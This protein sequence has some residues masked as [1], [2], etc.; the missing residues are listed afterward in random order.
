[1][2]KLSDQIRFS[3]CSQWMKSLSSV[4]LLWSEHFYFQQVLVYLDKYSNSISGACGCRCLSKRELLYI[5]THM[6]NIQMRQA[7]KYK[8]KGVFNKFL[9]FIA[10]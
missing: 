7:H 8:N 10:T 3:P 2:C 9:K 1:M 4:Q 5:D 6:Q